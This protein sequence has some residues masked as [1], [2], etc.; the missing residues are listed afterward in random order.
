MKL[1]LPRLRR[2][3]VRSAAKRRAGSLT[4]RMIG[5]SALWIALLLG[6]GGFTL[7]RFLT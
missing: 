7:D 4:G 6:L 1:R 3:W 5:I 2:F